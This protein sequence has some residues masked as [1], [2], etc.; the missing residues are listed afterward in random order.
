MKAPIVNLALALTIILSSASAFAQIESQQRLSPLDQALELYQ[1]YSGKT[2]LRSPNLP[3][4]S[5]FNKPIPSS[6][7]NGMKVVLENEL[8]THGIE[9][10]PLREVFVLAVESGWKNSAAA[11]YITSIK[12]SNASVLPSPASS[13][14]TPAEEK[15]PPGTIDFR[16]ADLNQFLELYGMMINRNL[17]R[18]M[19]ISSSDFQLRTQTPVTK[20]DAIH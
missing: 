20:D 18:S 5:E 2:V 9:F 11:S 16:S 15:I 8:T 6:D 7:I 1:Q 12:A 3:S 14:Q 19:Q 4:L 10:V 13:P 17:L